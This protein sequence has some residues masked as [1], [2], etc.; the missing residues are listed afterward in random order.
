[1]RLRRNR[2]F[3][4]Y[5]AGQ[6]LSAT[7]RA[8]S[9]VAYPLLV[10]ALTHSP[11]KAGFVAFVRLL[12]SPLLSLPAGLLADRLDRKRIMLA[13]D[14]VR[15][16][17]I[18]LLGLVV[19][20]GG[21]FWPIPLLAFLE[22][23][24]DAF[25][26][27]CSSAVLRSVVEPEQ[28]PEAVLV[29]QG[30]TAVVGIAGPPL[31]GA[32]F[33]VTRALPF[34]VDAVSYVFSFVALLAMRTPFQRAREPQPWRIRADLAEGFRFLWRQPFLR[35]TSLFYAIGNVTIQAVLFLLVVEGRRAGLSGGEIGA[36]LAVFSGAILAG[37]LLGGA[38]RRRIALRG[39]VL[40]EAYTGL[41]LFAFVVHPSVW[42]LLG[43]ALPQAVVLPITDSYVIAHRI[44]ATP[45][46]LLGRAEAVRLTIARSAQPL[47]PLLAGVLVAALS[48]R[49]TVACFVALS[50]AVALAVTRA[51]SLREPPP[52]V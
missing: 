12:P 10:L 5:Q 29:Q 40:C 30:R 48:A 32:L 33:T 35:T 18:G 49:A 6:L 13:S 1:M 45:D 44:A 36:L 28:L 14:L 43:A 15:A 46:H 16:V 19:W 25:F 39:V 27:A 51:R 11:A 26:S 50:A 38:V 7:G 20:H 9:G 52:L 41:L 21:A 31:G 34:A 24:G 22:G 4:L 23:T 42:V 3:L 37:S 2:D 8:F 17:G 47:G